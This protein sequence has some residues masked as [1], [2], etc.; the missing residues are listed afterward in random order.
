MLREESKGELELLR[1]NPQA[2]FQFRQSWQVVST[3]IVNVLYH[4]VHTPGPEHN[5]RI[6]EKVE[7]LKAR[8]LLL[9]NKVNQLTSNNLF[10]LQKYLFRP[11]LE[12]KTQMAAASLLLAKSQVITS[13][14]GTS[15]PKTQEKE[16]SGKSSLA[17]P[18]GHTSKLP[19]TSFFSRWS[20][21]LY[22]G[23]TSNICI[24]GELYLGDFFKCWQHFCC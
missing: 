17:W 19:L 7:R 6:Q 3:G 8:L 23:G 5:G 18:K 2:S 20:L 10:E 21:Y 4:R 12:H 24:W 15:Y 16:N 9:T 1:W 14:V 22:F 11:L 13:L